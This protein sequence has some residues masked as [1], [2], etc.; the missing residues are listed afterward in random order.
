MVPDVCLIE[1]DS[2]VTVTAVPGHANVIAWQLWPAPQ[3]Q[4]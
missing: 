4:N 2:C 1:L 3:Y